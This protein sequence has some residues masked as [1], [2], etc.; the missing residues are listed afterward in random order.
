[1]L[2][3]LIGVGGI[4]PVHICSWSPY[5][6]QLQ[7]HPDPMSFAQKTFM[8]SQIAVYVATLGGGGCKST[9]CCINF[10]N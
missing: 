3:E 4:V 7:Y 6:A 2:T 8:L 5:L 10:F 9:W 1:L